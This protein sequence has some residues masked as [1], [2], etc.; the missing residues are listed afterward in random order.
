MSTSFDRSVLLNVFTATGKVHSIS[1]LHMSFEFLLRRNSKPNPGRVTV[2]N[3]NK[4]S[5]ALFK[6]EGTAFEFYGGY[7]GKIG[8]C[9]SGT[10]TNAI[11][12]RENLD[13]KTDLIG[14]DGFKEWSKS[15]FS[16]TYAAGTPIVTIYA[17]LALSMGLPIDMDVVGA[18]GVT[19]LRGTTYEG[20]TANVLDEVS[21]DFGYE[22]SI[23]YGVIEVVREGENVASNPTAVVVN[24]RTGLIGTPT[25]TF[26]KKGKGF[27]KKVFYRTLLNADIRPNRLVQLKSERFTLNFSDAS[28][29]PVPDVA[30]DGLYI[31]DEVKF[32]GDNFGGP[33]DNEVL[34]FDRS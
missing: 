3:L 26:E 19:L 18:F 5:R 23:Q 20:K 11:S 24:S 13:W 31:A 27:K 15:Y 9:F 22:W 4:S 21:A 28:K 1:G 7:G 10:L 2:Y 12:E 16:K 14:S 8:K 17:D 34:S 29:K 33:F 25:I 6:E 32:V 30:A